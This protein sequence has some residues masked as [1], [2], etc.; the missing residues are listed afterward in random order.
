MID[1][2]EMRQLEILDVRL[3][4]LDNEQKR[5][6]YRLQSGVKGENLFLEMVQKY[7]HPNWKIYSDYWFSYGK[8]LQADFIVITDN[9]W[10][11]VEVK[12]Y[13]GLFEYIDNECYL[14]GNL[15]NDNYLAT[16]D[17]RI[18]HIR[19]MAHEINTGIKVEGLFVL[20][21]EN[22]EVHVQHP[23]DFDIKLKNELKRY[24]TALKNSDIKPITQNYAQQIQNVLNKY[25]AGTP[26]LPKAI[27][28]SVW[29]EL[30]RGITCGQCG[31]FGVN[32]KYRSL[33][34]SIC[35][36]TESKEQALIRMINELRLLYYGAEDM[37]TGGRLY[38]YCDKK[39]TSRTAYRILEFYNKGKYKNK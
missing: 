24:F 27:S 17:L 34:C 2:L 39:I 14:S 12:H 3:P 11:V 21:N 13:D 18:R 4:S 10:L 1:N 23:F 26:F 8:R 5:K 36:A 9:R 22:S 31:S 7:G 38:E 35:N 6:L 30:K 33:V 25:S 28:D 32:A 16:M 37:I 29:Q 15:L 20:I 19:H